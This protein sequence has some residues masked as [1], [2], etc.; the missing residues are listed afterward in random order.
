MKSPRNNSRRKPE[1]RRI[2]VH[3]RGKRKDWVAEKRSSKEIR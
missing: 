2:G 3:N 1:G